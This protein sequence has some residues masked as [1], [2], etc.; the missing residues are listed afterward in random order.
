MTWVETLDCILDTYSEIGDIIQG[1]TRYKT[2]LVKHPF[3]KAHLENYYCAVL[4]FHRKPLDVYSRPSKSICC[5][6]LLEYYH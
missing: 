2:L 5:R 1:L 4:E 6:A 3:I